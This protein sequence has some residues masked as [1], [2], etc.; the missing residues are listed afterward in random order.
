MRCAV[1][2]SRGLR[3]R[4][5]RKRSDD[6]GGPVKG[7]HP[8]RSKIEQVRLGKQHAVLVRD[9]DIARIAFNAANLNANVHLTFAHLCRLSGYRRQR[10]YAQRDVTQFSLIPDAA[11]ND[12]AAPAILHR[13]FRNYISKQCAPHASTAVDN[14]DLTISRRIHKF[15]DSGIVFMTLH[16]YSGAVKSG[17]A[18]KILEKRRGNA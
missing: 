1:M 10:F 11:K 3:S 12:D 14:K 2:A 8:C 7:P 18:T 5:K 17:F 16:R 4:R 15:L 6:A 13:L 9:N